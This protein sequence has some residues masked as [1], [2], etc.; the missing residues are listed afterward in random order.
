MSG[1]DSLK[2]LLQDPPP[3][4]AFEISASGIAMSRTRPPAT[5]VYADL[6]PGVLE[7]SPV[8]DNMLDPAAFAHAVAR[9]VPAGKRGG[10]RGAALILPDNALRLAVL[11]FEN[12]PQKD[13]ERHALIRF[14]LKKTLPFD[15]DE[16]AL[17]WHIQPGNKVVAAVAPAD[18]IVRYE[19][20]FRTLGLHPGLVTCTPLAMMD[21]LPTTG[22][23]LAA[24]QTAGALTVLAVREG[25]LILARTLELSPDTTDPLEEISADIYPTLVYLEDQTGARPDRLLLLGFGD[26]GDVAATRLSV[27]LEIPAAAMDEPHPGLAGY[28]K[29]LAISQPAAKAAA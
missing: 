3:E 18:L 4:F 21:L 10:R 9:L 22:F 7:P 6:A 27:E 5:V 14:R 11:D 8:K 24:H 2:A 26:E 28:L 16:A 25:T 12:L 15:V 29:S 19:S 17:S 13:E 1:L 23:I 20:A